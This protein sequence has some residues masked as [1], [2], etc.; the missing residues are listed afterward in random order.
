MP[1]TAA[2]A[3]VALT[4]GLDRLLDQVANPRTVPTGPPTDVTVQD[5]AVVIDVD[6][7]GVD[8]DTITVEVD[9]DVVTVA[10]S[11]ARPDRVGTRAVLQRPAG[12]LCRHVTL[13]C[14]VDG[15]AATATYD[16]GVLTVH[17]PR[18]DTARPVNV[19]ITAT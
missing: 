17:L 10:A 8:P 4:A 15:V 19:P 16:A 12:R 6:L 2:D 13:R 14:P 11:R 7:P 5:D 9:R 3:T 1:L 18:P